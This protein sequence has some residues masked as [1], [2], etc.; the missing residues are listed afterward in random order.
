M[1]TLSALESELAGWTKLESRLA[2]AQELV[3]LGD[4][5]LE[6]DLTQEVQS[7]QEEIEKRE[8]DAML[9]G[10]YDR[11]DALL[12]IHAGAGGNDAQD[13]A[14]IVQRMYLRWAEKRGFDTETLDL[15]P[16]EEAGIKS[17][18][19]SISGLYAYGYLRSEKGVHRL[20][21]ISPFDS[22]NRRHTSFVLVEILPQVDDDESIKINPNDLR[23]DT[24]RSAG[25]GG[26]SVQKNDTAV[27][28]THI[29]TGIVASCQNERSQTQN[30]EMAMKVLLGRLVA[31]KQQER[32][33]RIEELRGEYQKA[34]WGSQIRSYVLH[35]YHMVK[36]HRTEFE[37][38]NTEAVLD[39]DL[40]PFIESY[41]RMTLGN[42]SS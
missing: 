20:V 18:T 23:I 34:E 42:G 35:P 39:G 16:G 2:D 31:L 12:A 4:P 3:S 32:K 33:E 25:A 30:R 17:T 7:L 24:F 1:K 22:S 37:M 14:E 27:R 21:R 13:W 40:D 15:T 11:G 29:P 6:E 10:D 19:I 9:S 8:F 36:D 38:G 28:I 26:Q 5:S 41:L